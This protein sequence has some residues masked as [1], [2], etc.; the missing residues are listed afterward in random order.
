MPS[1]GLEVLNN[2]VSNITDCLCVTIVVAEKDK[3]ICQ[4]QK[5]QASYDEQ[6]G[7]VQAQNAMTF[8]LTASLKPGKQPVC[9]CMLAQ[10]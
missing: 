10:L 9:A 7:G 6:G 2:P 8:Y 1:N 4:E 3:I 5:T